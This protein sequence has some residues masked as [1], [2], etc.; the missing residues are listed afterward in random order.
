MIELPLPSAEGV[1]EVLPDVSMEWR[2][3][4]RLYLISLKSVR[5]EA[6]D[7]YVELNKTLMRYE[8]E[9]KRQGY[10]LQDVSDKS[11]AL[12]AYLRQKTAEIWKELQALDVD[13]YITF[14]IKSGPMSTMM[15]LSIN[16]MSRFMPGKMKMQLFTDR[17]KAL[18]FLESKLAEEKQNA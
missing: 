3:F 18:A 12:T 1:Y 16:A 2:H 10:I 4:G 14:V 9:Q 6:I 15:R 17:E 8:N 5:H 7:A 11:L 13:G